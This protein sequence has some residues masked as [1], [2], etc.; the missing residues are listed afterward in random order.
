LNIKYCN[1]NLENFGAEDLLN[2]LKNNNKKVNNDEIKKEM[3]SKIVTFDFL[4]YYDGKKKKF[5]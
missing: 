5:I 3:Y 2:K 1:F 4:T